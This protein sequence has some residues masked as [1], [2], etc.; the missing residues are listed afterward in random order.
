MLAVSCQKEQATVTLGAKIQKPVSGGSK[1]YIDDHTP[2]WHN[3]DMV[4]IND[5]AYP[6]M[7]AT[8]SSARIENV[9]ASSNNDYRAIF[10]ASILGST[11]VNIRSLIS[12]TGVRLPTIQYYELVGNHQRVDVPMG[13]YIS[14]GST[15]QFHNL[16]SVVRVVVSNSLNQNLSLRHLVLEAENAMLSGSGEY[17]ISGEA[18]DKIVMSS[19]TNY[20]RHDVMLHFTDDYPVVVPALGT[21]SFDIVVPAFETDDVTITLYTMDGHSCSIAK[22][23]VAL[24]HN[25]ITTVTLN[26]TSLTEVTTAELTDGPTFNAY[27]PNNATAVVFEYGN[28]TIYD[29]VLSST[30]SPVVIY[31]HLDGTTWRVTTAAQTIYA[32]SSSC[33][34]MFYRKSNITSIDFGEDGFN[35]ENATSMIEMFASCGRLTSLDLSHFITSNVTNMNSMFYWCSSLTS[36]DVSGFNTESVTRM[37]NMFLGCGSLTS[38]DLSS[39]STSSVTMMDNMFNQCSSL[40]SLDLSNFDMSNL[41]FTPYGGDPRSGKDNMCHYLSFY[42]GQCTITC[43]QAVEDAIKETNSDGNYITNLPT[44]GVTFTWVRPSPSSK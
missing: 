12:F 39:F 38:L 28:P 23:D 10:P 44:S 3:G 37:D 6:V 27:I 11:N 41:G 4:Y 7:A 20:A 8:G 13:A 17:R 16:C 43:P 21:D 35:T 5:A 2:C 29:T 30:E 24:A 15:L 42:S 9:T 40:L 19:S 33:A 1:V 14:S 34:R 31:G 36:L 32:C 18:T 22:E 26:V 25:T